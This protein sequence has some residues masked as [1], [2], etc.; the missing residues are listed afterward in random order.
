M[1]QQSQTRSGGAFAQMRVRLLEKLFPHRAYKRAYYDHLYFQHR[2]FDV[3][4]L[5]TQGVYTLEL[6]KVFVDLTIA[7][8]RNKRASTDPMRPMPTKLQN[9]RHDFWTYLTSDNEKGHKLVILGPPGSGKTTLLK[10][11]ALQ[12][13]S[14]EKGNDLQKI[15]FLLFL[16]DHA[17]HIEKDPN[18]TILDAL[19]ERLNLWE[20]DIPLAWFETAVSKGHC[21]V[22][23]DGLDEV[24]DERL[25]L[26]VVA[27]VQ[28]Q[29]KKYANNGFVITSRPFGYYSNPLSN[30]SLL[31]VRPFT[32]DQVR[33]FVHNW[34]FANEVMS[35]QRDD[36][37]VRMEA[38]K[39]G[40][41]LLWRLRQVP[42]LLEMAVNPLL[43]TMIATVHRYRSSLPG[44]RV[45]LYSEIC[46]VFLG[47]RQAARGLHFDLTP[48]QKQRVLQALA[49]YMMHHQQR[50]IDAN[51]AAFV[52]EQPL[53][54]V[55]GLQ[56]GS[57]G[58]TSESFLKMI[59]NSSGL[60][61]EREAGVYSFAHLTFQEYLA[62]VHVLDQKMEKDLLDWVED[63]WWHETIRLYAAQGDAT[64]IIK[65]CLSRKRP[66]VPALTLAM[67]CLEEAREV[68]PELRTIFE[69]LAQSVDHKSPEVRQIAAEVFLML[70]LRRMVRLDE[71]RYMD[72]TLITHAEYQ[73]FLNDMHE[74]HQ[75]HQPDHWNNYV[76]NPGE[77][78]LP[79]VGIRPSDAV[80]FCQW[81]TERDNGQWQYRIPKEDEISLGEIKK[82]VHLDKESDASYWYSTENGYRTTA[83]SIEDKDD[84]K[85]TYLTRRLEDDW[86]LI[87][88]HWHKSIFDQVQKLVL[89]TTE[90][91]QYQLLDI[92]RSLS[93]KLKEYP[94]IL[95][96]L[97]RVR[98]R[99]S[100]DV[101]LELDRSLEE[102][103][104]IVNDPD[105]SAV[106]NIEL[107][108]VLALAQTLHN[109]LDNAK[110]LELPRGIT[111]E[112]LRS[113]DYANGM[114]SRQELIMYQELDRALNN[115]LRLT[116]DLATIVRRA[117]TRA[118]TRLRATLLTQIAEK[119]EDRMRRK[120]TGMKHTGQST[121]LVLTLIDLYVDMGLIEERIQDHL[122]AYEGLRLVRIRP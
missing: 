61:I 59:E 32:L 104:S 117:Y 82:D 26:K 53:L 99:T 8:Q 36:P 16:R 28:R 29:M 68:R 17:D 105:L 54:R 95:Q 4:G 30:V 115:A 92:D 7:P 100:S 119:L 98:N 45:E 10:H 77:G 121:T 38:K 110:D 14:P 108:N 40:D 112:I 24:A 65:S 97:K 1:G 74:Q 71:S 34:Y 9:G 122:P 18:Y 12:L 102:A 66:S 91:R 20:V 21:L 90:K 120:T 56:E 84:E 55:I 27:W 2:S 63:S 37:G 23:L 19:A 87:A 44:R 15:P 89:A 50:E 81:L 43:L 22:M 118:R 80:A 96:D 52:I 114:A 76:F 57:E 35:A 93:K 109:E 3:K 103:I 111:Q 49:Y 75:Y 73:L 5:T 48:A 58:S 33:K 31:E 86:D 107:S 85:T 46:E 88:P 25:R 41:D 64:N 69:R 70:R 72:T 13:A 11:A 6:E 51:E 83:L 79:V 101:A 113:V 116:R 60:L 67:E 62:A 42:V 106:R 39:G 94:Q 78:R 47:K